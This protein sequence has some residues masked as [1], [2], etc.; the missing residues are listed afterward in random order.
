MK[1]I[2]QNLQCLYKQII[3]AEQKYGRKTGSVTLLAVS[4]THPSEIIRIAAETGQRHF[5]ESYMQEAVRKI[6]E[7]D[8]PRLIWHFIGP[9]QSN[10]TR[11]ISEN[12]SWVHSLDRF[13]IARRLNDMRPPSLPPL[14]ICIQL[15]ING[16]ITKS[17]IV[18][19]QLPV[20]ASQISKLPRLRFR[21]L[22]AMP[23]QFEDFE[24]QRGTFHKLREHFEQMQVAGY[25]LDTLSMGTTL[26]MEAAIAEGA[27]IVRIGTAIFGPRE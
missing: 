20:L 4:K 9:I 11:G 1:S 5:G 13:K 16:E 26:D 12:F 6:R 19:E 21:G 25:D 18:P 22:M 17:G 8:D 2:A 27:T 3:G 24:A 15:N 14:N 10:K 23:A 7:L